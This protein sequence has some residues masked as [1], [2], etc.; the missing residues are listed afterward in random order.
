[1]AG[2]KEA[3]VL[4]RNTEQIEECEGEWRGGVVTVRV[5]DEGCDEGEG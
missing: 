5:S 4:G 2:E 1:M 3:P